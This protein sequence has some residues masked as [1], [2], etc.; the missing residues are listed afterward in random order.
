MKDRSL[1][2]TPGEGWK[3][4]YLGGNQTWKNE[5]IRKFSSEI[6][7]IQKRLKARESAS[8]VLR[9]QH[10][11]LLAGVTNA[12]F[13]IAEEVPIELRNNFFQPG[14][15]YQAT[16]RFSNCTGVVES[17]LKNDLRGVAIR[18]SIG[19]GAVQDFLLTNASA[20]HARDP[21][22]FMVVANAFASKWK[23]LVLLR[24]LRGLG[25]LET[26]RV[27]R[28]LR[29][30]TSRHVESL[31]TEQFWSRC[32]IAFGA[33]AVKYM[34]QP[35]QAAPAST[36]PVRGDNYLRDEFR[37]RLKRAPIKFS[38]K[39]QRFVDER[40]TPI[41]DTAVQWKSAVAVETLAY[42]VIPTQDL[43]TDSSQRVEKLIDTMKF[44]PWNTT[45]GFQP[46]GSMN[47]ARRRVYQAS[48]DYRAS[49]NTS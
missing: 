47:R 49:Q 13:Q 22:Q 33:C 19:Q 41:E 7:Q 48:A 39:I 17:D 1:P 38:F 45:D 46:L 21:V 6:N 2:N 34:L 43:T 18:V 3:E 24:L 35:D 26:L 9:A 42:L 15:K 44:N 10:A 12:Q 23:I 30:G 40:S 27:L 31:A 8:R 32:P 25:L 36:T 4:I 16:V 5:L 29:K 11:K 14:M 28:V 37:E 20:S